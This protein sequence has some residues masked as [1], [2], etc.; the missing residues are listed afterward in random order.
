MNIDKT[1]NLGKGA[2]SPSSRPS[3]SKGD[4][5]ELE[6]GAVLA[7]RYKIVAKLGEGGMGVVYEGLDTQLDRPVALKLLKRNVSEDKRAVENL[8]SEAQVSMMLTHPNIMRLINFEQQGPY[9]FLL[10]EY[11]DGMDLKTIAQKMGGKLDQKT[12]A[13]ITIKVCSALEYAHKNNV[14]HRDIK[15]AN[16]M[17]SS[18]KEV[19]LMDFGIA[20]VIMS[21]SKERSPLAGTIAYLAPELIEGAK[22]DARCDVYALGLTMY[23]LLAGEHPYKGMTAQQVVNAHVKVALP[24]I[25][26]LDKEFAAILS[27][28]VEKKPN[29]RFQ[30]A[31]ELRSALG[32]H[33]GLDE[34]HNVSRMKA[35]M[36]HEKRKLEIEQRK[37]QTKMEALESEIKR[38]ESRPAAFAESSG[39]GF[40]PFGY[41]KEG[42]RVK[43]PMVLAMVAAASGVGGAILSDMMKTGVLYHAGSPHAN[44]AAAMALVGVMALM[45]PAVFKYGA[46]EWFRSSAIGAV[47]G[48]IAFYLMIQNFPAGLELGNFGHYMVVGGALCIG[49]SLCE[50]EG[51][52]ITR[53]LNI[54]PMTIAAMTL[55]SLASLIHFAALF[56][57]T[58]DKANIFYLPLMAVAIWAALDFRE[59]RS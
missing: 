53:V 43:F 15:P 9:A 25:E 26:G 4:N 46:A 2:D 29:A 12:V 52:D 45:P 56:R 39:P 33:L 13:N 6:K 24:L 34:S 1:M 59:Q 19:K 55:S 22:P 58:P 35:N 38:M 36:E 40:S 14:I 47:A 50:P 5:V 7:S 31:A 54:A 16:I 44:S 32:K 30:S 41:S 18:R 20:K 23:E 28:C 21:G 37:M 11:V 3:S 48:L 27:R 57:F 10:M 17:V 42:V 49:A 8:K 51:A